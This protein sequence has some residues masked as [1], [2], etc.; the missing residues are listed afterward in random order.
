MKSGV[1]AD[2]D[3]MDD[4]RLVE[5]GRTGNREAF[6]CLVKRHQSAV[7]A[8]A[9]SACGDL[10]R[11]EDLAQETFL[12]A[13]RKLRELKEPAKFRAWLYGIARNL[14]N[15]AFRQQ[16]RNPL[17][18]AEPLDETLTAT[19]T[20]ANPAGQAISREEEGILWRSLER[21]PDAYREPLVLYYREQQSVERV[22]AILELSED[23][24]RQRL[25]RGRKLLQA[26]VAAFVE[27][28]LARTAPGPA[29][30]VGVLT[31]LPHLP[32]VA[33]STAIG[34]A[35]LK[36]GTAVAC[37]GFLTL[38]KGLLIKF[39]PPAA[40]AW[41]MMKLPESQ[42][43]RKFTRWA[44]GCLWLGA[45]LYPLTLMLAGN[46]WRPY[47]NTHPQAYTLLIL[48]SAFGFVAILCPYTFWMARTQ[49]HIRKD[50]AQQPGRAG[51]FSQSQPYEYRSA[52]TFLGLPWVHICFNCETG[53]K[54][55]AAKGWI[56]IGTRAYGVLFASGAVAVGAISSGGLA[57]GGVALG[58]F[59]IGLFAF[60][61]LALGLAA[62]GGASAGYVALGGGAIGWL[63]AAGGAVMAH[64]FA[65][66]GGAIALHAN[67][68]AARTF[69]TG[70]FFFRHAWSLFNV[71]MV[72]SWLVPPATTYY[73]KRRRERLASLSNQNSN[74]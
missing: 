19:A 58:G 35:A 56:A 60:G 11:S 12:I 21:I 44:Y 63:G 52:G 15:S 42:R 2:A 28:T 61:G 40:G 13:W 74:Q 48:I 32:T 72:F 59:G 67:D 14:I 6:G 49:Q 31:A 55:R 26:E 43:E 54:T 39:V 25:S 36:G 64:D 41:M 9:Y 8:L 17:A 27:G 34:G 7:C 38:I 1:M 46:I 50:M 57:I 29:F 62:I 22:A 70:N 20:T 33:G 37:A 24:V 71:L 18:V 73:F 45:I 10:A 16:T 3:I 4:A 68:A 65:T 66:G 47:W 23:V 69:M 53:G 51:T 5:L 30:T